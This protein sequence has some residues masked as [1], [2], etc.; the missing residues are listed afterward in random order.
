VDV[1]IAVNGYTPRQSYFDWGGYSGLD[2][3]V[4]EQGLWVVWGSPAPDYRLH[5]S[6]IDVY[7]NVIYRTWD[8]NSGMLSEK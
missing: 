4:D 3:A 7:Q 2:L 8:F 5:A 6:K 1:Q